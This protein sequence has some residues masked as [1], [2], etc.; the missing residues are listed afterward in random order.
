MNRRPFLLGFLVGAITAVIVTF[1]VI[2][3]ISPVESERNEGPVQEPYANFPSF[4]VSDSSLT[5]KA[6][7]EISVKIFKKDGGKGVSTSMGYCIAIPDGRWSCGE[8]DGAGNTHRIYTDGVVAFSLYSGDDALEIWN[9]HIQG[10]PMKL[11]K[12][13][14]SQLPQT[15]G[16]D[17]TDLYQC[18]SL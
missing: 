11:T 7:H 3:Y 13:N 9:R 17:A 18:G 1:A 5:T 8:T 6:S 14:C 15:A 16:S 4:F 12:P 2:K 10:K